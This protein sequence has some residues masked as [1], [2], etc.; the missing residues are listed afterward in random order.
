MTSKASPCPYQIIVNLY[1]TTRRVI[2]VF[3]SFQDR[4]GIFIKSEKYKNFGP[5][6]NLKSS[7]MSNVALSHPND[8][9]L[10]DILCVCHVQAFIFTLQ[11]T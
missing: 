5:V 2:P 6:D 7:A 1:E 9:K 4:Y 3:K 11:L 8:A 10:I